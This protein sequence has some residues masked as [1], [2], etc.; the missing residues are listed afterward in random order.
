MV[1]ASDIS[2]PDKSPDKSLG[3]SWRVWIGLFLIPLAITAT[4]LLTRPA[5][6]ISSMT[7]LSGLMALKSMAAEATPFEVALASQK[8]TLVEF[9]ADWCTTC[10]SMSGTVDTLHQRY[11]DRVNF[12]MLDIDDPQWATQVGTFGAMGV[13]QFTLLDTDHQPIK[14]WVGKVPQSIFATIFDQFLSQS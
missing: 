8:P 10:Q 1:S 12:V 3:K 2:S 14:T 13:P 9:Y 6:N 11:G 5:A 7:P 4:M